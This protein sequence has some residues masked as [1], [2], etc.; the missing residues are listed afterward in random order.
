MS[1][2]APKTTGIP[3]ADTSRSMELA[4]EALGIAQTLLK[5]GGHFLCKVF[6]GED[7][8]PFRDALSTTF[9]QFRSYRPSAI[10]KGSREIYLLGL[11][12]KK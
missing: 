1:D 10:R 11:K 8:K 12:F 4:R 6:E 3:V 7:L 5:K 9:G 2:L